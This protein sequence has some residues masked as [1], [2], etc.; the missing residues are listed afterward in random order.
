MQD[1]PSNIY[2]IPTETGKS[3]KV[4]FEQEL[5]SE[6]EA[7]EKFISLIN[8]KAMNELEKEEEVE[9]FTFLIDKVKAMNE[10]ENLKIIFEGDL[11]R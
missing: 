11:K 10:P 5:I 6:K 9:K 2:I 8:K 3:V 4:C 1:F 7:V